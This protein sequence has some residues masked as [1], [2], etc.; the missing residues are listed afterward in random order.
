MSDSFATREQLTVNGQTYTI[1]SLEKLGH[2]RDELVQ[3][4]GKGKLKGLADEARAWRDVWS[5]GHGVATIHDAPPVRELCD[6]LAEEYR[7]A[8]AIPPSPAITG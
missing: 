6:R 4:V 3:G 7:A 5:A 8:C 2:Q 1:F